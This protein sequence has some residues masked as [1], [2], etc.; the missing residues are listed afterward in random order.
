MQLKHQNV[1]RIILK[2]DLSLLD[3]CAETTGNI[4]ITGVCGIAVDVDLDAALTDQ[5]IPVSACRGAPADEIGLALTEDLTDCSI[6]SAVGG[7]AAEYDLV[8]G[9]D[10]LRDCIM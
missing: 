8:A 9:F 1:L 6:G 7:E 3:E 10:I 5:H 4:G 2:V